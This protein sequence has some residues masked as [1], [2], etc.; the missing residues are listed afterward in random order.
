MPAL[1]VRDF[2]TPLYEELKACATANHRSIAQQT[3]IAVEEMLASPMTPKFDGQLQQNDKS[4]ILLSD[5]SAESLAQIRPVPFAGRESSIEREGRIAKR[6]QLF[7]E[8]SKISWIDKPVSTEDIVTLAREGRDSLTDRVW[9]SL[10]PL[11]APDL[12]EEGGSL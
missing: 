6:K 7:S 11:Q 9:L 10:D 1:Q 12:D 2:P 3:I 4:Q 5:L 8:F